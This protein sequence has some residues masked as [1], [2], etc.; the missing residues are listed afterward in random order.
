MISAANATKKQ[1]LAVNTAPVY[2]VY[3]TQTG[4]LFYKLN[5]CGE[6]PGSNSGFVNTVH[7]KQFYAEFKHI[8]RGINS[9][10]AWQ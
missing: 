1:T 6:I 7:I 10:T 3:H 2:L 8:Y 5:R 4:R 9:K